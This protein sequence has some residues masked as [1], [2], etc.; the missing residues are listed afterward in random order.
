MTQNIQSSFIKSGRINKYYPGNFYQVKV[1]TEDGEVYEFELEADTYAEAMA[2][3]ELRA[4]G[5]MVDITYVEVY[6]LK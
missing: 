6:I 1:N 3:A 2:Q 5:L 4:E